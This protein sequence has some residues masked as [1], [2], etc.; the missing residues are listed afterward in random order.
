MMRPRE[1]N[2]RVF[3]VITMFN[4]AQEAQSQQ[5]FSCKHWEN[6]NAP[7]SSPTMDVWYKEHVS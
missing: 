4:Y 3:N 6:G 2:S 5:V 1:A 7:N